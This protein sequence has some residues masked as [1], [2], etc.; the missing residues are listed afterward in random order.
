MN[1]GDYGNNFSFKDGP[2][3]SYNGGHYNNYHQQQHLHLH[4]PN[5]Q[6]PALQNR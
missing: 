3:S 6:H 4:P 5:Q 1:H 2:C